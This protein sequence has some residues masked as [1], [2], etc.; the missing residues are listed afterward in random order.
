M[1]SITLTSIVILLLFCS[2][3]NEIM[4]QSIDDPACTFEILSNEHSHDGGT[5]GRY[6][7]FDVADV[8]CVLDETLT[9]GSYYYVSYGTNLE[10]RYVIMWDD[11]NEAASIGDGHGRKDPKADAA[12]DDWSVGNRIAICYD[13]TCTQW[14]CGCPTSAPT[15]VP[16]RSPTK[17]PSNVP[18][19]SPTRLRIHIFINEHSTSN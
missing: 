2:F 5:I 6:F 10:T 19:P 3:L 13:S 11:A 7:N 17:A 14:K 15:K 12:E 8:E 9:S 16:S 18:T 4:S 1:V